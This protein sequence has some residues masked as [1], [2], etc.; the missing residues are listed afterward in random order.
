MKR[1]L[2]ALA[3]GACILSFSMVSYAGQWLQDTNGWW[4][5]NTDNSYPANGWQWIDGKCYYFTPTGYCLMNTTTPDGFTV[6][7]SGAWIVDGV[8]QTSTQESST[9]NQANLPKE[10]IDD[11]VGFVNA[12]YNIKYVSNNV[13][14]YDLDLKVKSL[15]SENRADVLFW[16]YTSY[17][18]IDERFAAET[19]GAYEEYLEELYADD[20]KSI[21]EELLGECRDKDITAFEK[22]YVSRKSKNDTYKL[23]SGRIADSGAY[24]STDK[25]STALDDDEELIITGSVFTKDGTE[26]IKTYTAYFTPNSDSYIVGYQFRRLVVK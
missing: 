25:V 2:T 16:Y 22:K 8:V 26:P 12:I 6:D 5:Q 15:Y 18:Q 3:T 23:R 14:T 13:K 1:F 7:A 17:K 9:E 21:M 20:F 10:D 19:S 11:L 24:L 4:Y